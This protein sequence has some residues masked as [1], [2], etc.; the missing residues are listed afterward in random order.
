MRLPIVAMVILILLNIAVDSY[1]YHA[2]RRGMRDRRHSYSYY[3]YSYSY[4]Y[5]Y[6]RR[7][8]GRRRLARFQ[9]WSAVILALYAVAVVLLPRRSGSE[10]ILLTTMWMLF[11]YFSIYIPKYLFLVIDLVASLPGLW[12]RRRWK[13]LSVFGIVLALATFAAMWWGALINRYSIDTRQVTV[14]IPSLP[15]EF[16]GYRIVQFSDLHLGTYGGDTAYVSRVVDAINACRGD[17]IM[18]TGDV[19]N[20]RTVEL[21]PFVGTLSRLKAVD[22]VFSIMGNHDYGD[23]MEWDS[24][25]QKEENVERMFTLQQMMGWRMLH[26]RTAI[27]RRGNDSIAV[28]GVG[29]IGE[30]PFQ[31]Y[32]S[33]TAAYPAT[34]DNVTKILLS[35]NPVHWLNSIKDDPQKRIALTLCGHTH[36]MQIAI[37]RFSPAALRYKTWGGLYLSPDGLRNLYVNIGIGTV[38]IPMRIGATPEITIITLRK[39]TQTNEQ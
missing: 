3:S 34:D 20:R 30:P 7:K 15:E 4:S 33:L 17:A 26:N 22:G 9:L 16:D 37:G 13:G 11:V 36:A 31:I 6:S 21:D 29:N 12:G 25:R 23:Y 18:F 19:V 5:D 10:R 24:E 35:H 32:G 38:G 14:Q 2:I 39:S 1:I 8:K 28:I 27:I